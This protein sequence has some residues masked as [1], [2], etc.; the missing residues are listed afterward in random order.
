MNDIG[1]LLRHALSHGALLEAWEKVADNRGMAGVDGESID[2]I[3]PRIHEVL[4]EIAQSVVADSYRP[5]PLRR[6]WI[7]KPGKKP[8]GL[9][10]PCV[11][12]R[13]LQ[14]SVTLALSPRVEAELEDCAYAYRQ[15]RG[16]RQAVERIG[17]Y[18]REGY[19]WIVDADIE[20]FFDTI[21]HPNLLARVE[22]IAPEPALLKLIELWL[23]APIQDGAE[24]SV[25]ESGIPQGSPISPLLANIYLDTLDDALL[26]ADHVLVRY[27]D[28]FVVLAKTRARAEAALD[29]TREILGRLA[30]RLNPLKTRIVHLDDGLEFLGWHF[31]RSFAVPRRWKEESPLPPEPAPSGARPAAETAEIAETTGPGQL[32]QALAQARAEAPEWHPVDEHED[33]DE[34]ETGA[35]AEDEA[36]RA[37]PAIPQDPDSDEPLSALPP[38]APLQRTLYLVDNKA[39]LTVDNQRYQVE[40]EGQAILTLPAINVDT[41]L[42]FGNVQVTTAALQLASRHECS[43]VF[44]SYFGRCYGRFDSAGGRHLE[45]LQSQ[46][47]GHR[48]GEFGLG[49]A[50]AVVSAKLHHSALLLARSQRHHKTALKHGSV[51]QRLIEIEGSLQHADS[52]ESLRGSEGAAA[53][54]Y[55]QAFAELLPPDWSFKRRQS[56]PAPDAIN[57]LLSLGY[58]I[59]YNSVAG[60]L[61]ARGLNAYLGHLHVPAGSHLALASDLMEVY[62]AY[63]VDATLLKLLHKKQI[64]PNDHQCHDDRCSLG[65]ATVKQF[66]R[67]LEDRFNTV[68]QHPQTGANMDLRRIIDHDV[69]ALVAAIKSGE[70]SSY[71]PTRWR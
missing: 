16:V 32:A 65:Q 6:V 69:L 26:D 10:V 36:E 15:G 11:R 35:K 49:F 28:D 52:I 57:A 51:R 25:P 14:T 54:L 31:V 29:L 20:S 22:S 66:I 64:D 5:Q 8:R 37:A 42:V 17:Y 24:R 27:A 53:A 48:D 43:V 40:R 50:R 9:A 60:L 19:R 45:L 18:Q 12:D 38:L 58:S 1:P 34:A 23:R 70:R 61:Q 68:Q 21:P 46:F 55:W 44:L 62:R 3:T 2:D 63:V 71:Q 56:H 33:E 59:L 4:T 41:I 7:P 39:R 30:L 13:I 47:A 67:A